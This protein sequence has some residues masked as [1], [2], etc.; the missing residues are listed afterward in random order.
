MENVWET[1]R[2][3]KWF[4]IENNTSLYYFQIQGQTGKNVKKQ[5]KAPET[6]EILNFATEEKEVKPTKLDR[7]FFRSST[8]SVRERKI[9][10]WEKYNRE[11]S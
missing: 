11:I 4:Q 3:S 1:L 8:N 5:L 7:P 9:I 10:L 2:K 6:A